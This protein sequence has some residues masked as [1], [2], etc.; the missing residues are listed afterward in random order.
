MATK[1][2]IAIKVDRISKRY[3]IG[4]KENSNDNLVEAI[5]DLIKSPIKNYKIYRSLYKFDDDHGGEN[6][7]GDI[8]HPDIIWA[9]KDISF[10][11]N[12]GEVLGIIGP[13]GAG[14][15]TLLKIL[16]R[17]THPTSGS[18]E[19]RGRVSTLIEVGTGFHP[20]LTGRENV[21]LNGTI[22]GM[23][24]REIGKKFDEIVDF[25]G[26]EKF[27]DT[28]VKR[29]S[30]GMKVRLAFAV[31]AHLKAE[32]IIVDEVLAVG[33]AD[34]QNKCI[35]K[36]ENA[37]H[38]GRTVLLVSHNMASI[39]RLCSR[40]L[41]IRDGTIKM[42]GPAGQ[43]VREYLSLGTGTTAEKEWTNIAEAP[44]SDVSRLLAVKVMDDN[45]QVKE[46]FD[47]RKTII[48]EMVYEVIK[49]GFVLLP[50]FS[51]TNESGITVFLTLEN[52]LQWKEKKRPAGYYVSRVRVPGNFL[53]EGMLYVS[54]YLLTM[55]P[56]VLQF[57]ERHIIAFQVIDSYDGT[58]AR[59]NWQGKLSG[60][61]RP[62]LDWETRHTVN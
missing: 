5:F 53:S 57:S 44:G 55:Y 25:S 31:A 40:A 14:K 43:V 37:G 10:E 18:A 56:N 49:G 23:T 42:D 16:S 19:I 38:D 30:S 52:D 54:C 48:I 34:F 59:G 61:V 47:I 4:L 9:L 11:L 15:S 21:Y 7:D 33:D 32:I 13:N 62:L 22:I 41:L 27:L 20:E 45:E 29:Y 1:E 6:G 60:V 35:A 46:S 58:S 3:R 26:V 2:D 50:H 28:P 39:T 51:L 12:R 36:M 24:K 17:I 8:Y